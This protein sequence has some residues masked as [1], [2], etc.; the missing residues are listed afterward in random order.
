MH[1]ALALELV[2]DLFKVAKRNNTPPV[3]VVLDLVN[4]HACPRMRAQRLDL[5]SRQRMSIYEAVLKKVVERHNVGFAV[6]HAAEPSHSS[7]LDQFTRLRLTHGF[8][9]SLLVAEP[10][11]QVLS[12]VEKLGHGLG[13]TPS[14]LPFELLTCRSFLGTLKWQRP[15][16]VHLGSSQS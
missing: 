12:A 13:H 11:H 2:V 5:L 14:E 9:D 6:I 1:N 15:A 10:H 7:G 3:K 4:L 16:S 8:G